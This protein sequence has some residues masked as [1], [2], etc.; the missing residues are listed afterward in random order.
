MPPLERCLRHEPKSGF[1]A[2]SCSPLIRYTKGVLAGSTRCGARSKPLCLQDQSNI[3]CSAGGSVRRTRCANGCDG[4]TSNATGSSV[5]LQALLEET[6][7][8]YEEPPAPIEK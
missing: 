4:V 1:P 2:L 3:Y 6:T 8:N 7:L 5:G